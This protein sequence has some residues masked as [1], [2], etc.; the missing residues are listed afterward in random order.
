MVHMAIAILKGDSKYVE[1]LMA[2]GCDLE[3]NQC[4]CKDHKEAVTENLAVRISH[5][6]FVTYDNTC[7]QLELLTVIG[8]QSDYSSWREHAV[9]RTTF[10]SC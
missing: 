2:A 4:Y 9:R 5:L 10:L 1:S 8:S 3:E 6:G 7:L